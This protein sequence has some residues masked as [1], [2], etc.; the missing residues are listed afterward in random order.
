MNDV[1]R[2]SIKAKPE[3]SEQSPIKKTKRDYSP[4]IMEC[5]GKI[6]NFTTG[7]SGRRSEYAW[8]RVMTGMGMNMMTTNECVQTSM[9]MMRNTQRC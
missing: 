6:S 8:M 5:Y 1:S 7:G 9:N 4:P 2:P 3:G